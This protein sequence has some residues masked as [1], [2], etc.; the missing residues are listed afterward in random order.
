MA[1]ATNISRPIPPPPFTKRHDYLASSGYDKICQVADGNRWFT[2]VLG[3]G[4]STS[5][6]QV[7]SLMTLV[8]KI[9]R[10]LEVHR[11]DLSIDGVPL[12]EFVSLFLEDLV[13]DRARAK[14]PTASSLVADSP[15]VADAPLWLVDLAVAAALTSHLYFV[16]KSLAPVAPRRSL[17]DDEVTVSA[18]SQAL[19]R[20]L[21]RDVI[22]PAQKSLKAVAANLDA[23]VR[24]LSEGASAD[25][26]EARGLK[27]TLE[28]LFRDVRGRLEAA[29]DE[30]IRLRWS[31]VRALAEVAWFCTTCVAGPRVYP[32]WTDLLV[33]LSYYDSPDAGEVGEPTFRQ[34]TQAERFIKGRYLKVTERSFDSPRPAIYQASAAV[35]KAEAEF[36]TLVRAS[37]KSPGTKIM[38]D[39]PPAAAFV[40][41]FDLELE[42]ALLAAG[43]SFTLVMPVHLVNTHHGVAHTCWVAA[44]IDASVSEGQGLPLLLSPA[45]ETWAVVDASLADSEAPVVVRLAGCPIVDLPSLDSADDLRSQ[46]VAAF[47]DALLED[48]GREPDLMQDVLET[49]QLNH[50]VVLNEHDAMWHNALD[51]ITD[52][53][54][55]LPS[56]LVT[57]S[58][59]W[60]RFWLLFGV[61]IQ[62][63]AVRHRIA[64][65]VSSVPMA[66]GSH[67][68]KPR[69]GVA[70][71]AR[72][73]G[74][75]KDLLSWKG[76]DLV[77]GPDAREFAVDL[78]HYVKHVAAAM[79]E[80]RRGFR[81][82]RGGCEL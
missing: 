32:G 2:I 82:V 18:G 79:V 60:D 14:S 30:A 42:L 73:A 52:F 72:L 10:S 53:E 15:L 75:E 38:G 59:K 19:G 23:A 33:D 77:A 71:N 45:P 43:A 55:S 26:E 54:S 67:A 9:R 49:L 80:P 39:A 58:G 63:S 40:T 69:V 27:D 48:C 70:V 13:H 66:G 50:A 56:S 36:R 6:D 62:D 61:Q 20:Y 21:R 24:D 11:S 35:L 34:L 46:L 12:G 5:A 7:G 41:S 78:D 44:S 4:C 64:T 8:L 16:S 17:Q 25:D 3:S 28:A 31:D 37:A 47:G 81:L 1:F 22:G 57:G 29:G 65:V 76:F 68:A 51:L 74:V